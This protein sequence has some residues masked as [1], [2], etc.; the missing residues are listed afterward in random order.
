MAA[1][2]SIDFPENRSLVTIVVEATVN[3]GTTST[4]IGITSSCVRIGLESSSSSLHEPLPT[5]RCPSI[6]LPR[7]NTQKR[8][9]ENK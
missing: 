2:S 5:F 4:T 3:G 7:R 1:T 8:P 6:A 9:P